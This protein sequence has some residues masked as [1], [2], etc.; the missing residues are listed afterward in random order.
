MKSADEN[1]VSVVSSL[2]GIV[3]NDCRAPSKPVTAIIL[4]DSKVMDDHLA[5]FE[6][7]DRLQTLIL[8][9]TQVSDT[10]LKH[11]A[12]LTVADFDAWWP[13]HSLAG[14][15]ERKDQ[16]SEITPKPTEIEDHHGNEKF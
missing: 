9:N 13:R 3:A 15:T 4:R 6:N 10:G 7:L 5:H 12:G 11:L 14:V 16:A 8:S 1:V 2:E